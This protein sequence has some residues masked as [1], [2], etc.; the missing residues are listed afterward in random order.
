MIFFALAASIP[1]FAQENIDRDLS[2]ALFKAISNGDCKSAGFIIDRKPEIIEMKNIHPISPLE[3][4]IIN[5][6]PKMVRF[7]VS[8]GAKINTLNS[9]GS[10][11]LHLALQYSTEEIASFLISRG[12]DVNKKNSAGMTPIFSV[13]NLKAAKML[14][15]AGAKVNIKDDYGRSPLFLIRDRKT[16][17]FF[18][19][20]GMKVNDSDKFVK[21]P[22]HYRCRTGEKY[23]NI[24]SYDLG[25]KELYIPDDL[26]VIQ[27]LIKNGAQINPP[28]KQGNTPL[29]GVHKEEIAAILLDNG[30][31][32]NARNNYGEIPLHSADD[33]KVAEIL[34]RRGADIN[35]KDSRGNAPV[36][37]MAFY[38]KYDLLKLLI[39]KGANIHITNNQGDAPLDILILRNSLPGGNPQACILLLLSHGASPRFS[40]I[41][42][43]I[44]RKNWPLLKLLFLHSPVLWAKIL[45]PL[46]LLILL[47]KIAVSGRFRKKE[48]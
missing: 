30:A 40:L 8:K 48:S 42:D 2:D 28:D 16:A 13:Q 31:E 44:K 21:S 1:I 22:L 29:F 6:N 46:F 37:S 38:K 4:A 25:I 27:L 20:K 35:A 43:L 24:V 15:K 26:G 17:E 12:A 18:I 10:T 41:I 36:H 7:L 33:V 39:T 34:I 32:V 11:P 14:V 45:V 47:V 9:Y 23:F 3:F 19:S 5:R